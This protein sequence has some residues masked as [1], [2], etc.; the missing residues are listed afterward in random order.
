MQIQARFVVCTP[1]RCPMNHET[2]R[3]AKCAAVVGPEMHN[4]EKHVVVALNQE[5]DEWAKGRK[6]GDIR[7]AALH[8][9]ALLSCFLIV[10]RSPRRVAL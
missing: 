3:A 4:A 9:S 6:L 8:T 10:C 2:E 7:R 1:N 5:G